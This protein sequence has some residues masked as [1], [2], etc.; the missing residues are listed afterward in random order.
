[1][2]RDIRKN[3]WILLF[4]AILGAAAYGAWLAWGPRIGAVAAV[5]APVVA[6]GQRLLSW[7]RRGRARGPGI[8]GPAGRA[9]AGALLRSWTGLRE[10]LVLVDASARLSAFLS[11]RATQPAAYQRYRGLLGQ[12]RADLTRLAERPDRGTPGEWA[13]SGAVSPPPL[14]RIVLYIDDLDRCPPRRVVEVLEAVHLMLALDLFVV[15]VA[16]DARWLIRSM[17]YH[18]RELFG[19]DTEARGGEPGRG[20]RQPGPGQPGRLPGQDLPDSV[21]AGAVAACRR[22]LLSAVPPSA[23]RRLSRL[24]R[25]RRL[26]PTAQHGSR[27]RQRGRSRRSAP[28]RKGPERLRPWSRPARLI[29]LSPARRSATGPRPNVR[30]A[31]PNPRTRMALVPTARRAPQRPPHQICGREGSR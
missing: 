9:A 4:W 27:Q 5:L 1:M 13:A 20:R 15:V 31:A 10:R 30:A 21:R 3:P 28:G 24:P 18:Y 6:I 19:P 26:V 11:D 8:A 22:G 17:E 14:E 29:A 7:H 16:V 25:P 12:V 2:L 23:P